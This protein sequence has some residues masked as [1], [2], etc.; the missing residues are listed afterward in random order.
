MN[1]A[2]TARHR[3]RHALPVL[4]I[5]AGLTLTACAADTGESAPSAQLGSTTTLPEKPASGA[6]IKIGFVSPEGG[7]LGQLP[8]ARIAAEAATKYVN[9]NL[10]GVAGRPIDLV[11]CKEKEDPASARDCANQLAGAG[12]VAVVAPVTGQGDAL[13][14]VITG[15]GIPYVTSVGPSGAEMTTPNSFVLT[16]GVPAAFAAA[17]KYS[18]SRG[19]K[20]VVILVNDAGSVVASVKS[21][22]EPSF[23]GAGV[24]LETVG[25]PMGTPDTTPQVS[26][27]LGQDPDAIFIVGESTL[28]TAV[29][30]SLDTL[31]SAVD[32][33]TTSTCLDRDVAEATGPAVEGAR[34]ISSAEVSSD[35]PDTVT[36]RTVMAQY[37]PGTDI[38]G[39]AFSGYQALLG[40]VRAIET[41]PGEFTPAAVSEA[42]RTAKAVPVPIG[43]GLTF[44]CDGQQVF[45]LSS[46]CGRG[47][48]VSTV[49]DGKPSDPQ[50][51]E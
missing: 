11:V 17:A 18:G 22:A 48:I 30:R 31:G 49:R 27:A 15:A 4:L 9:S 10:G 44:T 6:P 16:G 47:A 13:V 32:K 8:D 42:L 7:P 45:V 29:L 12:V 34:V 21:L 19:Y 38:Y 5:A 35:D 41:V 50:V 51:I 23:G 36:F 37:A 25:V 39:F 24:G 43:G 28:C 3:T 26:A 20:K 1:T 40:L 46:V 14:P 2:I 33:L